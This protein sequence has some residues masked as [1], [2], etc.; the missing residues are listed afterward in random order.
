MNPEEHYYFVVKDDSGFEVD[1]DNY[2]LINARS[3]LV[4]LVS[5]QDSLLLALFN[6][7]SEVDSLIGSD[8]FFRTSTFKFNNIAPEI[9]PL[10]PFGESFIK[11][12]PLGEKMFKVAI[13]G[14][15]TSAPT[16]YLYHLKLDNPDQGYLPPQYPFRIKYYN[17]DSG[18]IYLL[19]CGCFLER[20]K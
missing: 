15:V 6:Y 12:A 14:N 17:A 13:K 5:G 18:R 2:Q 10:R 19:E 4:G 20:V 16:E 8:G 3:R 11:V 1:L 7:S 9:S